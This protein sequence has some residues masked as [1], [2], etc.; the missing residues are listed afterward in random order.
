MFFLLK[1]QSNSEPEILF[2]TENGIIDQNTSFN[3]IFLNFRH[4][5]TAS[6]ITS[7]SYKI[8]KLLGKRILTLGKTTLPLGKRVSPA[9]KSGLPL[10]ENASPLGENDSSLGEN[11]SPLK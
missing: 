7:T 6:N 10:R 2:A 9:C 1:Y 3:N 5:P 4:H 11:D 8:I